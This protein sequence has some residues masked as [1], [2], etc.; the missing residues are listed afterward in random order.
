[1]GGK[2]NHFIVSMDLA[3][4]SGF[5]NQGDYKSNWI[6]TNQINRVVPQPTM[7]NSW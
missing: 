7:R 2:S 3:E 5:T 6:T 1:M 4:H